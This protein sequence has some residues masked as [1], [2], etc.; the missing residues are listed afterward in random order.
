MFCTNCFGSGIVT[1]PGEYRG[2]CPVCSGF[3]RKLII[4]KDSNIIS[5]LDPKTRQDIQKNR[6]IKSK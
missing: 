5:F 1:G 6:N 2:V 3:G 4:E